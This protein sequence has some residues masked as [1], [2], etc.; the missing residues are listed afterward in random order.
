MDNYFGLSDIGIVR[1]ENEDYFLVDSNRR[2][3]AVADGMGGYCGGK[4]ASQ[5][6][7]SLLD[8][9]FTQQLMEKLQEHPNSI[10]PEMI[11]CLKYA[12]DTIHDKATR[13]PEFSGMGTTC[14]MALIFDKTVHISHVGDSRAYL[15][16]KNQLEQ[17]TID[18]SYV[19]QNIAAG[20]MSTDQA[21][22]SGLKNKLT[23][24]L[25]RPQFFKPGY[26]AVDLKNQDQLLLCTD[27][28]WDMLDPEEIESIFA[29]HISPEQICRALVDKAKKNGGIDNITAVVYQH[30]TGA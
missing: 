2:M 5:M 28:L 7:I 26:S 12:C 9:H 8:S 19:A 16:R 13:E 21:Q 24:A 23:Q 27:G 3:Y 10:K 11:H 29:G 14:V 22:K 15:F 1:P 17:L 25:G 6:A 4:M 30:D 20:M 18:H